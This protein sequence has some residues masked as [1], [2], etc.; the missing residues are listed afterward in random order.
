M[1]QFGI[2]LFTLLEYILAC[3]TI[4]LE[5]LGITTLQ[6][7]GIQGKMLGLEYNMRKHLVSGNNDWED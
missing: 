1:L 2:K 5:G 7:L 4:T 6:V 3:S